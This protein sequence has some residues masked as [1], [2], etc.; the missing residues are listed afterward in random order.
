MGPR[1]ECRGEPAPSRLP[2]RPSA[3]QCTATA[4]CRG[5]PGSARTGKVAATLQCGHGTNAVDSH[6]PQGEHRHRQA[7]LL[8]CG[9]GTK[10]VENSDG[11]GDDPRRGRASMRPRHECRGE[12]SAEAF[13]PAEVTRNCERRELQ[14]G[15]GTKAVE[16]EMLGQGS[17]RPARDVVASM[18]PRHECRGGTNG[19][20]TGVT[21]EVP[22][23]QGA[24]NGSHGT[25]AV[26]S[27][28]RV[29]LA[30]SALRFGFNAATARMPWRT[31]AVSG[32]FRP[33][34]E[35]E[36]STLQCG[37]GTKAV[38][39][40]NHLHEA[41]R[42]TAVNGLQCGHGTNAVE[43][44]GG[45]EPVRSSGSKCFN[46]ATARRP[47]RTRTTA[48]KSSGAAVPIAAT[49]RMPWRTTGE[50][51]LML[52]PLQWG[53][54]SKA[55]ENRDQSGTTVRPRECR[56][57][58]AATARKPWRRESVSNPPPRNWKPDRFNGATARMPWRTII[59]QG[60]NTFLGMLQCGHGTNAVENSTREGVKVATIGGLQCGHGTN[61]VENPGNCIFGLSP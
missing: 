37:H 25:N 39:N 31:T 3:S 51:S 49:A 61:A 35:R 9:H 22:F 46:A 41:S 52:K 29:V 6:S 32:L 10:A 43:N 11:D 13:V 23:D 21:D 7:A 4:R 40:G 55:V 42:L 2:P 16:N 24:Y 27:V 19:P 57:F 1:H 18:R 15:H 12:S 8:Q 54:S 30:P 50:Q 28:E 34:P 56:C 5:E 14:C 48:T 45:D 36:T 20:R 44:L 26:D 60:E 17:G 58:N 47:W 53:H 59:L 38:E 33:R